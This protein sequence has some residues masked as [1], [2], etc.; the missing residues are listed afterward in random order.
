M[1]RLT[2]QPGQLRWG[3]L[4]AAAATVLSG[5]GLIGGPS[6]VQLDVPNII[7]VTSPDVNNGVMS[8][9]Y[10]CR[11]R[12]EHPG[13]HWSGVPQGTKS[14][15]VV[16][17]D[18]AAPISPYIYWIVF[19]IGPQTTDIQPGTLPVGAREAVNSNDKEGYAAP[20]PRNETHSYRFTVY[21][22]GK[23]LSPH[24]GTGLKSAWWAIA[25]NAIARG[26]L[27]VNV[28]P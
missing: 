9:M 22:L 11:G 23:M 13:L 10:T 14:I 19:D 15:A 28:D 25:Q 17:D 18:S 21:A 27:P 7:T 12:S 6:T 3:V 5:C 4:G 8:A 24:V 20:C 2:G 1:R 16:M 26:R